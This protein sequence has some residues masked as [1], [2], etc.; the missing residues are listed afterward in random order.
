MKILI[1]G[2]IGNISTAITRILVERGDDVTLYNRAKTDAQIPGGYKSIA[3]GIYRPYNECY[4]G[5]KPVGNQPG[6]LLRWT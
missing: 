2:G 6:K 4:Q 1:I 5:S 3:G